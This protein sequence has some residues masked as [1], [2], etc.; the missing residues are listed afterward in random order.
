M[1]HG[2]STDQALTALNVIPYKEEKE[3]GITINL[4]FAHLELSDSSCGM[5]DVPGHKDF[6]KTM[7]AGGID[8]ALL[9]IAADS[10]IMP[11]TREH[12]NI[13]RMLG[14]RHIIVVINKCDL[15][16]TKF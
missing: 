13:V 1:D 10:G 7:V 2:N 3:R 14:I 12:F 15:R 5:V 9:V 4:G 6:I 11:Q 16:M 8:L